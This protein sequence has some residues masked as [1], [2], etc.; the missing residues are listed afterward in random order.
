MAIEHQ[1]RQ[2]L[3][4]QR[5]LV[6]T[7]GTRKKLQRLAEL[8]VRS[9]GAKLPPLNERE[10]IEREFLGLTLP[11]VRMRGEI[12]SLLKKLKRD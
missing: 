12:E 1:I 10:N 7:T 3:A 6:S 2:Y 11:H 4:R 5:K 9:T 8:N